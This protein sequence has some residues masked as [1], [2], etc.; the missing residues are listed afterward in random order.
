MRSRLRRRSRVG[1]SASGDGASFS[2]SRR[3]RMNAS[4]GFE[5]HLAWLTFGVG[6]RTGATQAQCFF[7]GAAVVD[8]AGDAAPWSIDVRIFSIWSA[9]SLPPMGMRG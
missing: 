5:T 1:R 2:V 9:E 4:T 6:G 8:V 7:V 3:A